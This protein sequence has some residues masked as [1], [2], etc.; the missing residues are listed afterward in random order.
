MKPKDVARLCDE[1]ELYWAERNEEE[2]GCLLEFAA[3]VASEERAAVVKLAKEKVRLGRGPMQLENCA[4]G[5][6]W[7]DFDAALAKREQGSS[8]PTEI[9]TGDSGSGE[10]IMTRES[11][12][13]WAA[14]WVPDSPPG[15]RTRFIEALR[16]ELANWTPPPSGSDSAAPSYPVN[17]SYGCTDDLSSLSTFGRRR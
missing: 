14:H 5:I 13:E 16:A 3:L 11:L 10:Q 2:R 12:I 9:E 4:V 17:T 6:D 1:A 7:S 8:M 15:Q